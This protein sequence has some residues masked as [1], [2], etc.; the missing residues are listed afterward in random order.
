MERASPA[1]RARVTNVSTCT[2]A[3]PGR[4]A[5]QASLPSSLGDT[6]ASCI[7]SQDGRRGPRRRVCDRRRHPASLT[8]PGGPLAFLCRWAHPHPEIVLA[9]GKVF[10][11]KRWWMQPG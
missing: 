10:L 8:Q 1:L 9:L 7:L 5:R 6:L 4:I 2:G 11:R 3:H